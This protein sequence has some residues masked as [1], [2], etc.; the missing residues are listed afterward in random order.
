MGAFQSFGYPTSRE[1]RLHGF[2]VQ[3]FQG[4][5]MQLQPDGR[6]GTLNLLQAGL[7]PVTRINGSVFP[8]EDPGLV[9]ATPKVGAPEYASQ[10]VAFTQQNIPNE[11]DG[12]PVGFASA[13][14]A[15]IDLATAFPNGGG[16][17]A[18]KPL[19]ALEI[20][21]A[22]TSRPMRDSTN[23]SFIYQRF[24]RSIM[25]YREACACTERILLADWFKNV[26]T[27]QDVP[28]DL[29]QQMYDSPFRNQWAP[30]SPY[31]LARPG[32]LP[33]SDFT[34]AFV[35]E[36]PGHAMTPA[37]PQT[38]AGVTG[39]STGTAAGGIIAQPVAP[40][41]PM[42]PVVPAPAPPPAAPAS[43]TTT[44]MTTTTRLTCQSRSKTT[45]STS[46]TSRVSPSSPTTTTG[47]DWIRWEAN[48]IESFDDDNENTN[49]NG[50]GN[51]ND[52]SSDDADAD[53]ALT[54]EH[55]FDCDGNDNCANVWTIT[56]TKRGRYEIVGEVRDNDGNRREVREEIEVR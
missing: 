49:D 41:A 34:N 53:P 22:P 33:E 50:N 19:L 15:T 55:E 13:F 48:L 52:N 8:S 38:G 35:P 26:I 29:M 5:V 37:A 18:L 11:F 24:Q 4:H 23:P 40:L 3:M 27:G 28:F 42:A 7:M 25:H 2:P 54:A 17:A 20:W 56:T 9:A 45:T 31:G 44:T 51:T 1:F 43:T 16:N 36:L 12:R 32:A 14:D 6:V 21:G 10:M 39:T 30:G 46:E 47:I